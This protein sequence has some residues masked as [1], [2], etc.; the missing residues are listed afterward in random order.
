MSDRSMYSPRHRDP[1]DHGRWTVDNSESRF[2][3]NPAH[4]SIRSILKEPQ[5]PAAYLSPVYSVAERR[6]QR[7]MDRRVSFAPGARVRLFQEGDATDTNARRSVSGID[8]LRPDS[9]V[10]E[11]S[12]IR[13][14]S[15]RQENSPALAHIPGSANDR[16]KKRPDILGESPI[17]NKSRK[18]FHDEQMNALRDELFQTHDTSPGP[19]LMRFLENPASTAVR[20]IFNDDDETPTTHQST[21]ENTQTIPGSNGSMLP[22]AGQQPPPL[23]SEDEDDMELT[24]VTSRSN[25]TELSRPS[26]PPPPPSTAEE[27]DME[28]TQTMELTQQTKMSNEPQARPEEEEHT[29]RSF[30]TAPTTNEEDDMMLTQE[31]TQQHARVSQNN[32]NG[33][34][35]FPS[36]APAR[37]TPSPPPTQTPQS[38]SAPAV[39]PASSPPRQ[40]SPSPSVLPS[41]ILSPIRSQQRLP[42][43]LLYSPV[44][45]GSEGSQDHN[46]VSD[47]ADKYDAILDEEFSQLYN[48][49]SDEPTLSQQ[50]MP[51]SRFLKYTSITFGEADKDDTDKPPI[52]PRGRRIENLSVADKL[53]AAIVSIPEL[54]LYQNLSEELNE[55]ITAD[56]QSIDRIYRT[57]GN[58]SPDIVT[59]Y[60]MGDYQAR[61]EMEADLQRVRE[62]ANYDAIRICGEWERSK[63]AAFHDHLRQC[64]SK[65]DEDEKRLAPFERSMD[66]WLQKLSEYRDETARK[67]QEAR[68]R[69]AEYTQID[70]ERIAALRVD[71]TERRETIGVLKVQLQNAKEEETQVRKELADMQRRKE[72]IDAAIQRAGNQ[73]YNYITREDVE[74]AE[75]KYLQCARV[76]GIEANKPGP[77]VTRVR[78]ANQILLEVDTNKLQSATAGAVTLSLLPAKPK[79]A[80]FTVLF[81]SK[82]AELCREWHIQEIVQKT[83]I[84]WHQVRLFQRELALANYRHVVEIEPTADGKVMF[85]ISVACNEPKCEIVIRLHLGPQDL[86]RFPSLDLSTMEVTVYPRRFSDIASQ[87]KE[88]LTDLMQDTGILDLTDTIKQLL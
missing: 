44:L 25:R 29:G 20:D 75:E 49:F 41:S 57:V 65:L 15:F 35:A 73:S 88:Q 33:L 3:S 51:L 14:P 58:D 52:V 17:S 10:F 53:V 54:E 40:P 18:T 6:R 38:S 61:T 2:I 5:T 48:S 77:S 39:P 23:P 9:S 19:D 71:V 37:R 22:S 47:F 46:S 32:N 69:E 36:S 31:Y 86:L 50:S 62:Q 13:S 84:F 16:R 45:H 63:R 24:Q 80:P 74:N 11:A 26:Q 64:K 27:G 78:V 87:W 8:P 82:E 12:P 21:R 83:V 56:K 81:K 60:F 68:V 72:E 43:N 4:T 1:A 70:H 79:M 42:S 34:R 7:L 85:I 66:T 67:L 28:L 30:L 59:K 76:L 55:L